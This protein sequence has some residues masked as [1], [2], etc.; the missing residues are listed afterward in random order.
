MNESQFTRSIMKK[1]PSEIYKWKIMNQMQNGVPD[2]YFSGPAGDLWLEV[3]YIK[4]PKRSTTL[5][6]PELS[7][8]Q[9]KWLTER[10]QEKRNVALL[11]GSNIGCAIRIQFFEVSLVPQSLKLTKQEVVE[12]IIRQTLG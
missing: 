1:L 4:A 5:I 3:K 7:P 10:K 11:I 12:W 6:K 9:L 8:L 2:C